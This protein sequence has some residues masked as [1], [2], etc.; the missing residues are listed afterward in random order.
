MKFKKS[1]LLI[2]CWVSLSIT[3]YAMAQQAPSPALLQKKISISFKEKSLTSAIVSLQRQANISFAYDAKMLS[4]KQVPDNRNGFVNTSLSD[5]LNNLL[6]SQ[7]I[8][9]KEVNSRIVLF[10]KDVKTDPMKQEEITVTGKVVDDGGLPLP[11]VTVLAKPGGKATGTNTEGQFTIKAPSNGSLQFSSMGFVSRELQINGNPKIDVVLKSDDKNLDEVVVVAYG[12]QK[13]V[14]VTGAVASI[15]TKEIKQSPAA[16]LAVTLA[17]RLPGLTAIQNSGEPGRDVT[18]LYLR[19]LGTLNGQNPIILVDGVERDLGYIDPNE[20]ENITILKD[21]SSTA[22]FGVRGANGVILVTTKRG[23]SDKPLISLTTEYGQQDFTRIPEVISSFDWVNLKN[24]A[25]RNDNPGVAD[26]DPVN[27]PPYSAYAIERFRLQDQPEAYPQ[28]DWR[29]MLMRKSVPQVRYN[30]NLSG[31][32]DVTKYFVNLGFLDQA[33]QWKIADDLKYNPEAF[34]K[35]YNFRSNIDVMLNKSKTLKTFLNAAGYL[36]KVNQPNTETTEILG[37]INGLWPV[38]QPGPLAPNGEVLIGSSGSYGESPWAYIN[39]SGYRQETRSNITA[40]WGLEQ[41]LSIVTKGL[42]AKLMASFDTKSLYNLTGNQTYQRWIQS[43]DPNSQTP[44]G[45]DIVKYERTRTDLD[46]TPLSTSTSTTFESFYNVQLQAGYQRTFGKHALS[47]L[48]LGQQESRIRPADRLPYNLLG[49]AFRTSYGYDSRYFLEFNM[50]YNGSEQFAKGKRFGFFPSVSGAWVI[51]NEKFFTQNE[52]LNIF[53]IRASY[54]K[55]GS[56]QL[57]SRR[58]LYLDDIQRQGSG[59]YSGTLG[60]GGLIT[61]NFIG[62]PNVQWEIAKKLNVGLDLK[63]FQSLDITLD[64]FDE[65]RENVLISRG[66]VPAL[67]GL[68]QGNLAPFNMGIVSNKGYELEVNYNKILNQ[69]L[70]FVLKGNFNK[71]KNNLEFRDEPLL[72]EE[73]AYRTRATGYP[74]GQNFGYLIDRYFNSQQDITESGLSYTGRAPRPGDF[75]YKD[76]NGDKIIDEK[77]IAPI[78]YSIVPQYTFG[79]GLSINFKNIDVSALFQGVAKVSNYISSS[80]TNDFRNRHLQSWTAERAA[81]GSNIEYPALSTSLS[82]SNRQNEFYIEDTGFIRLKN[83]E[84]GFT[85]P[86][87]LSSKIGAKSLRLYANGFNLITWDR[88]KNKDID[89]EL[90]GINAYPVYRIFNGGINVIF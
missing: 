50:G 35:R 73:Y 9:Y 22:L 86:T 12:T 28:N 42:T 14:T 62:N 67:Y 31:G 75:K 70:S 63:L 87:K 90:S 60:R 41:D 44:D 51:S 53:K 3:P 49:V 43:I 10:E 81:S 68:P 1:L 54:G 20:V 52:L 55:V 57:G 5:V 16:N 13:K 24:E 33:G 29:D 38:V 15:S 79:A 39:R 77:D 34:L 65:N 69:D 72:P 85:F 45:K 25:W 59:G 89:P 2:A 64:Y 30:M 83:V 17:G 66:T 21:A 11:G 36:E 80:E 48:L 23:T 84:V 46:N 76:L 32:G 26:N 58:F 18:R 37:R 74:I 4:G 61:E 27:K 71:A 40:S 6:S 78:G 56:D 82:S 47:G 7:G 88:L 19:G 8:N